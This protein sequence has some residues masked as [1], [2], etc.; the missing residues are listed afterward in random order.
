MKRHPVLYLLAAALA[1]VSLGASAGTGCDTNA[2]KRVVV[3]PKPT[4]N[5][6]YTAIRNV[7]EGAWKD[8]F[9]IET[10]TYVGNVLTKSGTTYKIG[11]LETVWGESCRATNRLL[12][13]DAQNKYLGQYYGIDTDPTKIQIRKGV[14]SFPFESKDGNKLDLDEGPPAKAWLDGDNPEWSAAPAPASST[15]SPPVK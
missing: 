11:F 13:F 2:Q 12:I 1:A 14:L 7:D 15:V 3:G 9:D 5:L 4:A 8:G 10:F 6:L